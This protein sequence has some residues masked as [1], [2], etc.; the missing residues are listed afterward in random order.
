MYGESRGNCEAGGVSRK[1]DK[2]EGGRGKINSRAGNEFRF[3][4]EG[5]KHPSFQGIFR[6]PALSRPHGGTKKPAPGEE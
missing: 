6:F 2:V 4:S 3:L 5:L 1:E